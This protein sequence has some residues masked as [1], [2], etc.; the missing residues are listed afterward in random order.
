MRAQ[1]PKKAL[2]RLAILLCAVVLLAGGLYIASWYANRGRIQQEGE[3]YSQLYAPQATSAVTP[4]PSPASTE[5][6]L[7][8]VEDQPLPDALVY[9][10]PTL[11]P[12]QDSFADLTALNPETVGFLRIENALSLP[13]VQREND[14]EFYLNH[15]FEQDEAPEGTLFLDGMNRLVPED[16]CLIIYGHNMHNGTMFGSLDRYAEG[17]YL[18]S[19]P[20]VHFDTIYE[21][22]VYVPFAAFSAS[23]DDGDAS[24]FQVRRF[25]PNGE[26][27]EA[28]IASLKERSSLEIPVDV[29]SGDRL[30]LLVTCDY[31][32][33]DGRFILA[34]RQL[35]GAESEEAM[36]AQVQKAK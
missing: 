2:H 20:L 29:Q 15:N 28:F 4:S 32:H 25:F 7:P 8:E 17:D 9:A 30:L 23:M 16:G 35:R 31:S 3:K 13:V 5:A 19:H 34:L 11:P 27:T 21:N 14:N 6:P 22:R 10:L 12:V 26:D 33:A 18:K 1:T 36:A 24:F